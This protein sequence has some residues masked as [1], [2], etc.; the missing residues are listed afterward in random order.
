MQT[1]DLIG[2]SLRG[3]CTR[4]VLFAFSAAV[5]Y[6]AV[7][8]HAEAAPESS[9]FVPRQVAYRGYLEVNNTPAEGTRW[10]RLR[11]FDGEAASAPALL[12][13]EKRVTFRAGW[14]TVELG[15]CVSGSACKDE[16]SAA[17][18]LAAALGKATNDVFLGVEACSAAGDPNCV[19]WLESGARQR[20]SSSAF[21]VLGPRR[22]LGIWRAPSAQGCIDVNSSLVVIP[23]L[24]LRVTLPVTSRLEVA[25][26]VAASSS[27]GGHLRRPPEWH[28]FGGTYSPS[29][30]PIGQLTIP[31][32]RAKRHSRRW[33]FRPSA[34]R[35]L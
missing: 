34:V 15:D 7:P 18:T 21:G 33:S 31:G 4:G 17:T 23:A 3:W 8:A 13:E 35:A 20:L 12:T 29:L 11:L 30:G 32:R 2:D 6:R 10:L 26:G 16:N 9:E 24:K 5:A 28:R 14:Y 19:T 27:G 25:Y 1:R 22:L